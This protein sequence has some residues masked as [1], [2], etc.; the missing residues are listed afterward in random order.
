MGRH[1]STIGRELNRNRGQRGDRPKQ[2]QRLAD[3][4]RLA[5]RRPH[6]IDDPQVHQYVQDRLEEYWSPDQVVG[7]ARSDFP[8][9]PARWS[10]RQTVYD[11]IRN[12]APQW[13]ALLHRGGRPPEKREN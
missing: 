3:R 2:A 13:Q 5:S 6:K 12:R 11:W 1:R 9:A 4:R 8:R 7:R 10:S